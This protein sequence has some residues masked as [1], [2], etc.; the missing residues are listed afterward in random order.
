A[1]LPLPAGD[2]PMRL[3]TALSVCLLGV[4]LLALESRTGRFAW[5]A[6]V[7]AGIGLLTLARLA[8]GPNLRLDELTAPLQNAIDSAQPGRMPGLTALAL[9]A[10]GICVLLFKFPQLARWRALVI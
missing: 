10:A 7:P 6:V 9:L 3:D 5:L 8:G 1:V 2:A 4:S